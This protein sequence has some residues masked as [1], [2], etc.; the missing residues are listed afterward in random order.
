LKIKKLL[1]IILIISLIFASISAVA[2]PLTYTV[3]KGDTLWD[4]GIEYGVGWWEIQELNGIE[5]V[6]ALQIGTV[7]E[8]PGTEVET[9]DS[10][11]D[12]P[13]VEDSETE[14]VAEE[15]TEYPILITNGDYEIPGIVCLPV[16]EGPFPAV[17]MLHGTGSE[18]NEAGGGYELT[19]PELAKSGIAS[20]RIDFIGNGDSTEDY[21]NYN[22]TTAVSDANAAREYMASL[23][24]VDGNR[25]GIM[26]WSQG[27]TIAMLAA[28][29]NRSFQSVVTWAGAPDLTSVGNEENYETAK[30][31]GYYNLTFE[32]REPLK[33]GLQWFDEVYSTDVLE[34]FSYSDAPVL[35]INGANDTTVDPENANK[36]VEASSNEKSKT[37]F[38]E[39]ADH[40]FNIFT[41]DMTAFNELISATVEWFDETLEPVYSE[42]IVYIE[43]DGRIVPATVVVPAGEGPHPSVVINHGHGGSRE[44]NGGFAGVAEALANKGILSIRMDFPGCGESTEPFTE[45][46]LSNMISDSNASLDYILENYNV[47]E[48]NLGIFGYSMGGRIALEIVREDDNP[49]EAMALL[50]PSAEDGSEMIVSFLGGE[51]AYNDYYEEASSEKGYADFTTIYG[52]E[53]QLS[54]NWFEEMKESKPLDNIENFQG[55]ILV[56]Y[57]DMDTTVPMEES[58]SVVSA[59]PNDEGVMIPNANHG[60]GFYSD[61][62][63]VTETVEDQ[64][65][66]FFF[67]NFNNDTE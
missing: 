47:D 24:T 27:G 65:A 3:V 6:R 38:I 59:H 16:G 50:A 61:Q 5:D 67:E 62:P 54:I 11:I 31:D 46:Y 8:I 41:G 19:A 57:G 49:Y 53:Q 21:I 36:I 58:E 25:I 22:Y 40:T 12:D 33:L 29:H 35:A 66:E 9:E 64:T 51:E 23:D 17:I 55:N 15:Y 34:V 10:E 37:L 39:N 14:E 44:E 45:N 1:P 7:L 13:T 42:D 26:G 52:Q 56:L 63:D 30:E 2:A 20:I 60:Y 4:I 32:W 48:E 18:K 43:N 28:G